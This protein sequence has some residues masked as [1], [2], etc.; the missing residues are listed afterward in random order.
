MRI[1]LAFSIIQYPRPSY[2]GF[3]RVCC[4][5]LRL[6]CRLRRLRF[7]VS[8]LL[9]V[10]HVRDHEE[11]DQS[12]GACEQDVVR[13][14]AVGL[15]R[16]ALFFCRVAV[17]PVAWGLRWATPRVSER[18]EGGGEK[19]GSNQEVLRACQSKEWSAFV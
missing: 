14:F 5:L 4:F 16:G 2:V 12:E 15:E 8:L 18:P 13:K 19:L 6:L 17:L 10:E 9:Q 1:R 3:P 11:D 7:R